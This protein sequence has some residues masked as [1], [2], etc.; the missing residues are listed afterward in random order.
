VKRK[1]C[2]LII[3]I[4][5]LSY[6][7][8][9]YLNIV[10]PSRASVRGPSCEELRARLAALKAELSKLNENLEIVQSLYNTARMRLWSKN[11]SIFDLENRLERLKFDYEHAHLTWDSKQYELYHRIIRIKHE[12][13]ELKNGIN[14]I[15]SNIERI[16]Q[17]RDGYI[18]MIENVVN[19]INALKKRIEEQCKG[20]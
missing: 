12:I 19:R 10:E 13:R 6:P 8:V 4:S 1:I 9:R 7:L 18:G 14:S 16:L 5:V 2:Y 15:R 20:K 11:D 3:G 17:S